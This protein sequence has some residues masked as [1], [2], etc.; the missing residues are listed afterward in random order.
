MENVYIELYIDVIFAISWG[1]HSFL[2]WAAG[3]VVGTRAKKWRIFCGG[4]LSA[5]IYC[6]QI[7]LFMERGGLFSFLFLLTIG[8][9]GAYLPKRGRFFLRLLGSG[10]LVSF[11]MGGGMMLLFTLTQA[12]MWLGHGLVVQK[13]YPW[14]LLPWSILLAYF[15]LKWAAKWLESHIQRRR[16]FCVAEVCWREKHA[17]GR[18]LIDTGNGLRQ[19]DGRGVAILELD[20]L[21]PLFAPEEQIRLLSSSAHWQEL[22]LEV[23][24]FSSLGNA[25]GNLYGI[26]A[27]K[28]ELFFGEKRV[29]H[30]NIFVGIAQ[31]AFAGAYEG[32]VPPCLLEEGMA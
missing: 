1:M 10:V 17:E 27:E 9:A 11:L 24:S 29:V 13:A 32:L 6:G 4:A 8:L 31:D 21:L 23:L 2:L 7:C 12:Q 19:K 20:A 22:G 5:G 3:R 25:A 15:L 28:L 30:Q 26:R 16:E 14:W 18:V